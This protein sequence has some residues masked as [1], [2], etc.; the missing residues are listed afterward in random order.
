MAP[1]GAPTTLGQLFTAVCTIANWFFAFV[2]VIAVIALIYAGYLFFTSGGGEK[3]GQAKKALMYGLI[4]AAIV[5]LG[6]S[7]VLVIGNVLGVDVSGI[8]TC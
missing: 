2:L 3:V 6:K 5:V 7:L 8:L 4:G 1:S